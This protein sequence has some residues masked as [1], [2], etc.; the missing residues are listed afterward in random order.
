MRILYVES[1][2]ESMIYCRLNR[3]YYPV[4][5]LGYGDRLGIWVQGCSKRCEGCMSPEMQEFTG[6]EWPVEEVLSRIPKDICP[7]GLTISG[8]EPFDQASAVRRMMEWFLSRYGD[9]ILIYT[10]YRFDE[11]NHLGNID[12]QW[13]VSHV[14]A[15][16]DGPYMNQFNSG[17]GSIGSTN[18]TLYVFRHQDRYKDF[19]SKERTLQF[20]QEKDRLFM[21]GVLPKQEGEENG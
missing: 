14:A 3:M 10:G 8:G 13:I 6:A 11:L 9:D 21:I 17:Y 16:V 20:V 15:L 7:D 2:T 1:A 5:T 12:V 18:Q 19:L 4:K